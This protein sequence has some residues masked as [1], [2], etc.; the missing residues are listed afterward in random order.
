S[1]DLP[2]GIGNAVLIEYHFHPLSMRPPNQLIGVRGQGTAH[3]I[4][5]VHLALVRR[6]DFLKMPQ[7][8][9]A[10]MDNTGSVLAARARISEKYSPVGHVDPDKPQPDPT[11]RA[12]YQPSDRS[13]LHFKGSGQESCETC[14]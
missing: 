3:E 10:S 14:Q 2:A 13:Q 8:D 5:Y 1:S 6:I 12:P 4:E 9:S 7:L 11:Q